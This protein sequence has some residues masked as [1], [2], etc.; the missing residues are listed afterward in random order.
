MV[1]VVKLV[2]N[3]LFNEFICLFFSS[4]EPET[5]ATPEVGKEFTF[6]SPP[7]TKFL[8]SLDVNAETFVTFYIR[9]STTGQRGIVIK[10]CYKILDQ[11]KTFNC[12]IDEKLNLETV[13]PF[14]ISSELLMTPL[15]KFMMYLKHK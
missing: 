14:L 15:N 9:S 5:P 13:E 10:A 1:T 11:E 8:D 2:N 7:T 6:A 4:K 12:H 3:E